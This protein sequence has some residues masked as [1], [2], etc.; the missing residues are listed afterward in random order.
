MSQRLRPGGLEPVDPAVAAIADPARWLLLNLVAAHGEETAT[1]LA[2][3]LPV[4]RPTVAKHLSVL[5]RAGL[6]R[7]RRTGREVRYRVQP[8]RLEQAARWLT[9]LAS[10]WDARLNAIKRIA[11]SLEDE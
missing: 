11:E 2:A 6:E 7:A 3:Q 4:S 9:G 5:G 8:H 10:E 1:S